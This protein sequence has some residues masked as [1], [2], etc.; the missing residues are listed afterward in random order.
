MNTK[1]MK[2]KDNQMMIGA[3]RAVDLAKRYQ[4]PLYI[5]DEVQIRD[6]CETFRNHFKSK[7]Y[8]TEIV[9]ASKAFLAPYMCKIVEEYGFGIDSVSYG[10]LYLLEQAHF[11]MNR[12]VMHGNN[13]SVEELIFCL[14]KQVGCLV[15]DN[16]DELLLLTELANKKK[17]SID[18]L[19]RVNPGIEAHTHEYIKTSLI[20]S[21]FGESIFDH[22]TI[23][24]M[25]DCCNSNPLVRLKGF[26]AHIGSNI[27]NP[28]A[29]LAEVEVMMEFIDEVNQRLRYDAKVLNLGGGFAIKYLDQDQEMNLPHMLT[30]M[31]AA[32]DRILL[33][34][35]MTLEKVVIEPGR[36]IVGDAGFTLYTVGGVKKTFGG[37]NYCFVDGG[38]TDNIRPALYQAKYTVDV[39]NK[40]DE[41]KNVL[42]DVVGKCCESG[43]IVALDVFL[44]SVDRGDTILVHSTGA[45]AYSM[46]SNYNGALKSEVIFIRDKQIKTAV[47]REKLASLVQNCVL[48]EPVFFDIHT[49]I[50][51]DLYTRK[52]KGEADR[53]QTFH[54]PQLAN[55]N[56]VAGV[57][58]MYSPD[59]F[60]LIQACRSAVDQID[61]RLLPGFQVILGL[62]GLRNLEKPEDI[63]LL[64]EM[65]FRHAM[66][67]WN[68]ENQYATGA[69]SNPNQGLKPLG[70]KLLKQM[71]KLGMIIDVAHL[72]EKSFYDVLALTDKNI[73]NS[74]GNVRALCNHPRNLTDDQMRALRKADG[75][76]G[77]TL[78]GSFIDSNPAKRTVERFIDHI[79]HALAIMDEDHICFGFDFMDY[80]DEDFPN[81]N[82]EEVNNATLVYRISEGLKR[83][84]YT[85]EQIEKMSYRNFYQRYQDKIIWKG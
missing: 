57:W 52:E 79:D 25:V 72:N 55:S 32:I 65:G 36:S 38:M 13:K 68:E 3:Y 83:R 58:T 22:D 85:D 5:Y 61:I 2:I 30:T 29:F 74:H 46:A 48:D 7:Y 34:K 20:N 35:K 54:V 70:I 80:L 1:T 49:D 41:P 62:E 28:E 4:T 26:H 33:E 42:Y 75:L 27:I 69:K 31:S 19:I 78:A 23:K 81:G 82:I 8:Q 15:V 59:S 21:K 60:D 45:Y 17:T 64:Y 51:Y 76:M 14:E 40:M 10:D 39:A 6:K 43:D 67:T 73:I 12:V 56:I 77:L 47:R 50:L 11:P 24:K 63:D 37:K 53:F 71:E 9:Y 16:V 84:G 66:L 18:I 44:P